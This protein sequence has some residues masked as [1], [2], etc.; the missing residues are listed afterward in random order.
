MISLYKLEN[1]I[2]SDDYVQQA[3]NY[4]VFWSWKFYSLLLISRLWVIFGRIKQENK[5]LICFAF[6]AVSAQYQSMST[7]GN[8]S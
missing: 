2:E 8:T 4:S 1:F 5:F 7:P 3:L 6:L